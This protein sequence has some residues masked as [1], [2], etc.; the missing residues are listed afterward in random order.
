VFCRKDDG[1]PEV[2]LP[3]CGAVGWS[4]CMEKDRVSHFTKYATL[5]FVWGLVTCSPSIPLAL[6]SN[7]QN[8]L[9]GRMF[10][11]GSSEEVSTE[12]LIPVDMSGIW[13]RL[14]NPNHNPPFFK[15]FLEN[16]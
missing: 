14:P 10:V 13:V 4:S 12:E 9:V 3:G 11:P 16:V 1:H 6:M 15:I 2:Q 5:V 7:R 8:I